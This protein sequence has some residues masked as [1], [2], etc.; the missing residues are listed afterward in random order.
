MKE[1]IV[2]YQL[3]DGELIIDVKIEDETVWLSQAQL[4]DLFKITKQNISLPINNCFKEGELSAFSVV[5]E[6]LTTAS[7]GKKYKLKYYNPDVIIS[8]GYRVKSQWRTQ[9]RIWANNVSKDNHL[10]MCKLE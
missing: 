9:F 5:K 1:K 7:D 10:L 3:K 8:G 6:F 4:V 2:I